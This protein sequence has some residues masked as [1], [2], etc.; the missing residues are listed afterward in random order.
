MRRLCAAVASPRSAV[1]TKSTAGAD[2]FTDVAPVILSNHIFSIRAVKL[3][4]VTVQ[5]TITGGRVVSQR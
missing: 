5:A 3:E 4:D 2:R 1:Q